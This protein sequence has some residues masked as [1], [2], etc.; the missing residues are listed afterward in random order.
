MASPQL[1]ANPHLRITF[2]MVAT[3][4]CVN[5]LN[6][7]LGKKIKNMPSHTLFF[8]LFSD[9]T[10]KDCRRREQKI[11]IIELNQEASDQ[12]VKRDQGNNQV[13]IIFVLG[14]SKFHIST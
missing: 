10:G 3:L 8:F 11:H 2:S 6:L 5:F 1:V 13:I 12:I 14:Y 4:T 9:S 7:K